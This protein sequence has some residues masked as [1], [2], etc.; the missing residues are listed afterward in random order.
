MPRSGAGGF[1]LVE[2][3]VALGLT[4][5][6]T[7]AI[8]DLVGHS[9]RRFDAEP[10]AVDRQQRIRV[11]VD[12]LYRDLLTASVLMPYR[13]SG[14]SP[15][16]AGTFKDDVLTIVSERAAEEDSIRTYYV[17][18]DVTSDASHLM[19]AEGGGGDAPV[20][21]GVTSLSF[22]YFGEP[23]PP[24][25]GNSEACRVAAGRGVLVPVTAPE[26]TDGPWCP[27]ADGAGLFDADLL[28]VRK[29]GVRL[30]VK[31]SAGVVAFEVAPR[32]LNQGR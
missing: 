17:R 2:V 29:I 27:A 24:S 7:A 23:P 5:V 18:H 14:A 30:H 11:A 10:E 25:G 6:V 4:L 13:A 15:D 1:S 16:P 22:A 19:R 8:V 31:A 3:V 21:D 26:F 12:A 9:R 28:R 20:A 32:N